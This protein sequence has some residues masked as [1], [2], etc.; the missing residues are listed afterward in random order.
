MLIMLLTQCSYKKRITLYKMPTGCYE[1]PIKINDSNVSFYI[2]DTGA[3]E[4][5]ISLKVFG[6]LY[7][8][9]K[10]SDKDILKPLEYMMA[11][12]RKITCQRVMIREMDLGGVVIE[13]VPM[14]ISKE[15]DSPLLVGSNLLSR[16]SV[17]EIDNFNSCM[18]LS[19]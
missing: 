6:E 18:Y 19:K 3:S 12:G 16:F 7:E 8:K 13:N 4:G 9:G 15:F 5:T 17:V 14:S 2:L 10:I 1:V 11:D